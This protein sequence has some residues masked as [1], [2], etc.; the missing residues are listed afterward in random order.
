MP[1]IYIKQFRVGE[2]ALGGLEDEV[3]R[4][5]GIPRAPDRLNEL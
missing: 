2:N 4:E 1:R 5:A 3:L